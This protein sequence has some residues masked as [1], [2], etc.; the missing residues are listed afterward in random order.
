MSTSPKMIVFD[1]RSYGRFMKMKSNLRGE[2]IHR[3]NQQ[4]RVLRGNFS[5]RDNVTAQIQ[6][7]GERQSSILKDIFLK[8]DSS[9]FTSIAQ[10][11]LRPVKRNKLSFSSIEIIKAFPAPVHSASQVRLKFRSQ[12]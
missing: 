8:K 2:K 6:F 10:E 5:D 12:L 1:A 9:I 3:T 11:L 4:S 7:R